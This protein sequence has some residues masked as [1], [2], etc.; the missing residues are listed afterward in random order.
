MERLPDCVLLNTIAVA[1][2]HN[3]NSTTAS[4]RTRNGK[5]IEVSFSLEHPPHPSTL[6]VHS[7]D[8]NLTVPPNIVYT[9]DDLLLLSVNM[10]SGPYSLSPDD[11]DFFVYRA[12]PT[13][14]S[15][16]LLRRPHPYFNDVDVGL[17]PRLDGQYT[18]AAL[19]PT[20]TS[21]QY[22]LHLFDSDSEIRGWSRRTLTVEAPQREF[23][24]K[25]PIDSIRLHHHLTSNVITIGGKGGTMGW[26]DLWRGIL[27]CDVLDPKPFLRG[28]PLPLPLKELSYNNGNGFPFGPGGQRRGISFIRDVDKG[29]CYLKLV[30][31]EMSD[32]RLPHFDDETMAFSFRVHNWAL[33]TW[34]N[35]RMTDSYEDWHQE[36]MIE[37]SDMRIDDPAISQ[38][39]ETSGLL[40]HTQPQDDGAAG[41]QLAFHNLPVSQPSLCINGEDVVYLLAR[42]KYRHQEAWIVAVDIKKMAKCKLWSSLVIK[43]S[44]IQLSSIALVQFPSI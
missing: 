19:L 42:K 23:P 3:N 12:H 11:C 2:R 9:V 21:K 31:L 27:L 44:L 17:L 28:L 35:T 33:T 4:S 40:M 18:I 36:Y 5:T 8:M 38:M 24:V 1:G 32:V 7:S 14:P 34:S 16:H 10:G 6:L 13:R 26:V 37:A 43:D 41:E 15:L 30:H 22:E 29:K 25:I 39:L 20:T